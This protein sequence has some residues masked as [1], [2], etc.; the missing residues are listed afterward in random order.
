MVKEFRTIN[1]TKLTEGERDLLLKTFEDV[2][3]TEVPSILEQLR[4]ENKVRQKIDQAIL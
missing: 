3:Y 1:P 2:L 4:E